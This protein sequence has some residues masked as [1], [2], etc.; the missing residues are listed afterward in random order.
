MNTTLRLPYNW[1]PRPYQGPAWA[2]LRDGGTRAVLNWHRRSG[3]DEVCLH[4]VACAAFEKPG[5]YWYMLPEY[6]QARK[7][8]WDAVNPHTGKRRID[9]AFPEAIRDRT[10][11]QTMTIHFKAHPGQAGSTFQLVGADNFKALVGSPPVGL[12]FSE[13]AKTNPSAWAY[14][15]PILE[16][17]GGWV[18]FNSTPEGDNHFRDYCT[19]AEETEGWFYQALTAGQTGV[20][21]EQQ[22]ESIERELKALYGEDYG[23]ALYLQEYWCSF[24]AA[25]PGSIWGDCLTKLEQ[26]GRILDFPI[27]PN[28]P[29]YTGWDLG[30]TDDTAI[31]FYQWNGHELDVIGYHA[32]SL[33]DIPFYIEVLNSKRDEWGI[34]Y[35]AHWLPHDARPRRLGMGGKSILQQ[36]QEGTKGD[37][38]LGR[39]A[40]AP[41]LDVQEG[42]QAGRATF[43]RCR[44]HKTHCHEG[45][46]ALRHYHREWDDEK[47]KFTD[48]PFHDWA[49]HGA[50]AWR[51]LSLSWR[52]TKPATQAV[53]PWSGVVALGERQTT[54]TGFGKLTDAHLRKRRQWREERS[55]V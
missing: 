2:Y 13:M 5:N 18:V 44:F 53:E 41:K 33:R 51:Y 14:L 35:A 9:E 34:R 52:Q 3:K 19:L 43:P 36:L 25:I 48:A 6:A 27:N 7:A 23:H 17:N 8:M 20:F 54:R 16:E 11:D 40:I 31:W 47:K 21:S 26:R 30:R 24:D 38:G 49:S 15:M 46:R 10:L 4:H 42:I 1:K 37:P 50:D 12:I 39:F 45:L 29:V 22:L 32:S 28:E 55:F